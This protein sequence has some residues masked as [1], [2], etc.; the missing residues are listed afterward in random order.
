MANLKRRN[1]RRGLALLE[2]AIVAMFLMIMTLG[3]IEYGWMFMKMGHVTN[4]ARHGARIGVRPN[5]TF[6]QIQTAVNAAMAAGNMAPATFT[7]TTI[8][9]DPTTLA[10]GAPL[11]VTVDANYAQV[12]LRLAPVLIP[13]PAHLRASM[14][15]SREGS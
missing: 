1:D 5:A 4:A 7:V 11:T 10:T 3:I 14:V 12:G 6:A 13:T 15:M 8:P 2:T 9:S